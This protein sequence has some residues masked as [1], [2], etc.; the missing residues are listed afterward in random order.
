[1][2]ICPITFIVETYQLVNAAFLEV[3]VFDILDYLRKAFADDRALG[4]MKPH[5]GAEYVTA[6]DDGS[7]LEEFSSDAAQQHGK[8]THVDHGGLNRQ[9]YNLP[10]RGHHLD[11]LGRQ[12]DGHGPDLQLLLTIHDLVKRM[13]SV[14]AVLFARITSGAL[15]KYAAILT[16]KEVMYFLP[17]FL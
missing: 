10:S 6:D 3:V 14:W 11:L 17:G 16:S 5:D 2:G 9:R 7:S 12:W 13:I 8:V 1:M 4:E 15:V